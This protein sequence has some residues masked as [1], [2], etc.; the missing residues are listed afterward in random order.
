MITD[1]DLA[2]RAGV[3]VD[4]VRR[5]LRHRGYG[6]KRRQKIP[7]SIEQAFLAAHGLDP[8][9]TAPPAP[10]STPA[11]RITRPI[12]SRP[13]PAPGR[14]LIADDAARRIADLQRELSAVRAELSVAQTAL[15]V[16]KA[17]RRPAPA[18]APKET[19]RAPSV[20]TVLARHGVEGR[21]AVTAFEAIWEGAAPRLL[22][23]LAVHAPELFDSVR[24]VCSAVACR[25]VARLNRWVVVSSSAA[26]CSNCRGSDNR[27][28]FQLMALQL[29]RAGR[30]RVLVVG[31]A[32]D[33]HADL[34][35]LLR[36]TPRLK[37]KIVDGE[38]RLDAS[39]ARALV[40]GVDVIAFWAGSVLPHAVSDLLKDAARSEPH[41]VRAVTPTGA[42]GVASLCQA[43]LT[44]LEQQTSADT[45]A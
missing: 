26:R 14:R 22:D 24:P 32:P 35:R 18:P 3:S 33:C 43:V 7:A 30:E 29:K 28:W 38:K 11:Q 1:F 20:R 19:P 31:G 23:G 36:D 4:A 12:A 2:E 8:R 16:A 13:K 42:R 41:L 44:A 25:T 45:S 9:G 15:A 10:P 40:R 6:G 17:E 21:A 5:W 37:L 39:R 27:R 34:K